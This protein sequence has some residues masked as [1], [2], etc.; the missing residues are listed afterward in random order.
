MKVG[1]KYRDSLLDCYQTIV[2]KEKL[3]NSSF[4]IT[5]VTGL[6]G[7][8][9]ADLLLE[10]NKKYDLSLSIYLA[11]RDLDKL[12]QR[13]VAWKGM[14]NPVYYEANSEMKFEE[15]VDYIVHCAGISNPILYAT[16]PVETILTSVVG[17]YNIL[18]YAKK[19]NV[20]RTLYVSSS[21]VYGNREGMELY[22][23]DEY[24]AVDILNP[25]SCYPS[26]KRLCENLCVCYGKEYDVDS[27]FVR[28]GH[29]YGPTMTENDARA[30]AQ[31]VRNVIKNECIV[32]KSSGQQ[33][34]SYCYVLDCVSAML[35]V[36]LNGDKWNAYNISN[37]DAIVTVREFAEMHA[38][39]SG[40]KIIYSKPNGV[41]AAGYNQ[42]TCSALDSDKLYAL[43]WS[44]RYDLEKGVQHTIDILMDRD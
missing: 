21:E 44:G 27:L 8:A 22:K 15:P 9:V 24:A 3:S 36:L 40:K 11:A 34:R 13:F 7:S 20:K 17:T 6:I 32:M 1:K 2:N 28:P 26:S 33:L 16:Q 37:R 4:L 38:Q 39:L 14:Y 43:G 41:E 19:C 18:E 23:E 35:T 29:I 5:G 31:F 10:A 42:M 12:E 30:H 25:R